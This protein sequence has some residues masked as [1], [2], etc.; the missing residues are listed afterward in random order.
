MAKHPRHREGGTI[1]K[2]DGHC[3]ALQQPGAHSTHNCQLHLRED[4]Y[5]HSKAGEGASAC[6]ILPCHWSHYSQFKRSQVSFLF[7]PKI[8]WD[9][10]LCL[11]HVSKLA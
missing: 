4:C 5:R 1:L 10:L 11:C 8:E 3:C 7:L 9:S 2:Q 6:L